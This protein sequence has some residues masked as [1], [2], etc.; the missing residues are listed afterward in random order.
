MGVRLG[1][2]HLAEVRD[3]V[4]QRLIEATKRQAALVLPVIK[5]LLDGA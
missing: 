5:P 1:N 3:H 4:N 2:P